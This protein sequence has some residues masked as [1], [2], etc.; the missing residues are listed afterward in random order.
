[1]AT[2]W[3][4][5]TTYANGDVYSAGD[6]NDI[7]G[8][9]N[10][11]GSS[12][13]YAAGKNVILN[14]D[15]RIWQRGTSFASTTDTYTA[16]RWKVES[17]RTGSAVSQQTF[18]P[19]AAPVAGYEGA[20]YLRYTPG[21]GGAYSSLIQ[22]IEDVRTFANTTVTLSYWAKCS[23]GTITNEPYYFQN[24]GS[25]GSSE[26]QTALATSTITTSWQRFTQSF[27]IPSISGKTIG[28]SSY[29][30]L[31]LIRPSAATSTT[32]DVWGVQLE[33]G[34]TATA[35]QTATGTIQG[36]LAAC[37]RYYQTSLPAG[38]TTHSI[39][40]SQVVNAQ[41][42]QFT[43]GIRFAVPMRVAPTITVF[44]RNNNSGKISSIN[45]GADITG[46]AQAAN[47]GANQIWGIESTSSA[48]TAGVGYEVSFNA[49]AE[50]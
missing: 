48:L 39:S 9:I 29:L 33:R 42:T 27:T 17:N 18:T 10:L 7:T 50:L 5:K 49:S 13:A 21:T 23:T 22:R 6:V 3:P 38:T 12:V 40:T 24:F 41:N 25:G 30:S 4:M 14:A 26:V 1:M 37:M 2:G 11:L 44:G 46:V 34:S 36:E 43:S 8:T 45:T 47:I 35:F 19:G 31:L 28:T 16:D 20:F 32:V 15:Y